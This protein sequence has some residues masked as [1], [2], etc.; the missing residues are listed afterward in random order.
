[1]LI[2][3]PNLQRIRRCVAGGEEIRIDLKVSCRYA[4]RY[5]VL[6]SLGLRCQSASCS[7]LCVSFSVFSDSP[8]Y[9]IPTPRILRERPSTTYSG[10]QVQG[11]GCARIPQSC[12]D[13]NVQRRDCGRWRAGDASRRAIDAL[14]CNNVCNNAAPQRASDAVQ[15][16]ALAERQW[17]V[18]GLDP[19]APRCRRTSHVR[20]NAS[21]SFSRVD[22]TGSHGASG[23]D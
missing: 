10:H 3:D 18:P 6:S 19:A 15:S 5:P 17:S 7:M 22:S 20:T 8:L 2:I 16:A 12:G 1:M 11:V 13:C 4:G 21:G 9:V 14:V 23:K